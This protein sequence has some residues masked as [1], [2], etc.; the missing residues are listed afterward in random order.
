[1]TAHC[2]VHGF[3]Q[4]GHLCEHAREAQL[5]GNRMAVKPVD[6]AIG[7]VWACEACQQ[8][9]SKSDLYDVVRAGCEQCLKEWLVDTQAVVV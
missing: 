9:E 2:S 8:L 1:M 4:L 7:A 6:C 5:K 3:R